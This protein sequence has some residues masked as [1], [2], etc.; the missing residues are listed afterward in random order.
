MI[1]SQWSKSGIE[2]VNDAMALAEKEYKN[3][4]TLKD[5]VVKKEAIKPEWFNKNVEQREATA[6]EIRMLEERMKRS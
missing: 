6:S 2:T 1:A 3:K 5:K 4:K